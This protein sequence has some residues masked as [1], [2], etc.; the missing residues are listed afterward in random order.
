MRLYIPD[1]SDVGISRDRYRELLYFCRQYP[2]WIRQCAEK[3]GVSAQQY[4]QQP[5]GAGTVSDPTLRQVIA[6]EIYWRK[7]GMVDAAADKAAPEWKNVLITNVCYAVALSCI[8]TGVMPTTHIHD[9]F[10]AKKRFF[11]A[12][13][14]IMRAQ[15]TDNDQR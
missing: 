7:V 5:H 8:D 15:Y 10:V 12:L 3:L 6:R 13:D 2:E 9:Y 11:I 14:A 4:K 1:Y